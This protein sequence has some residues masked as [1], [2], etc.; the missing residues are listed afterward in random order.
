MQKRFKSYLVMAVAC[1]I[2]LIMAA[3]SKAAELFLSPDTVFLTNGVG[4]EFDLELRVDAATTDLKLYQALILFDPAKLDTVSISE[5]PMLKSVPSGQ[6]MFYYFLENFD[7][8]LR[9][10]SLILGYGL[11]V[12]GPGLL[13]TIRLKVLDTGTVMLNI[14]HHELRNID[15]N[16]MTST[17]VG[18]VVFLN[19]PPQ[20]FDLLTPIDG[21]V[22]ERYPGDQLTLEWE[23]TQS[24]YPGEGISYRVEYSTSPA[25][26]LGETITYSGVGISRQAIEADDLEEGTYYWR[27][28]A[29]GDLYGFEQLNRQEVESFQFVRNYHQPQPFNLVSPAEGTEIDMPG[30]DSVQ[31]DW[32]DAGSAN[33][34]D[35][36]SYI[37]YLGP[38]PALPTGAVVIDSS[39]TI[40]ELSIEIGSLPRGEWHYWRVEAR[41]RY[42][43]STWSTSVNSVM[44][45]GCCTD[46]TMG[47]VDCAGIIDIGDVTVMIQNLFI[48]LNEPCCFDEADIDLTGLVDIGDLTML[49]SSLFITLNP[50]QECP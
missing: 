8:T 38:N 22:M 44:F 20:Q 12:N 29:V 7:T 32:E 16:L 26:N 18:S 33:P 47:N 27:V 24:V 10:Q 17:A 23:E 2:I 42:G 6:T 35:T 31:F 1:H 34:D 13:A 21:E 5:G 41:N 11:A 46:A 4:E 15:N 43:S 50:L 37:L 36:T 3:N 9:V 48:T 14:Y 45:S 25:F 28:T 49:I 19:Y 40:S 39:V 30:I